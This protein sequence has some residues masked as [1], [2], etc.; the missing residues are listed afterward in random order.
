[1][2]SKLLVMESVHRATCEKADRERAEMGTEISRLQN[3]IKEMEQVVSPPS[4]L[5][6]SC[7]VIGGEEAEENG[8]MSLLQ[9]RRTAVGREW[10]CSLKPAKSP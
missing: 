6:N 7:Q 3:K 2:M 8:T 9:Q 1:M 4:R 10:R 5:Q